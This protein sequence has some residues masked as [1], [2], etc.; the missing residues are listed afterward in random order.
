MKFNVP[1][2]LQ[3]A[4][5]SAADDEVTGDV[6]DAFANIFSEAAL[7]A[8]LG[9][10]ASGQQHAH[11]L[12]VE[13]AERDASIAAHYKKI[14]EAAAKKVSAG[15]ASLEKRARRR[16]VAGDASDARKVARTE[17]TRYSSGKVL[18]AEIDQNGEVIRVVEEH[19]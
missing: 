2:E 13:A 1:L 17:T 19:A 16:V 12:A 15:N 6:P 4:F 8:F 5:G 14:A 3:E 18:I 9:P 7:G 10:G 11:N